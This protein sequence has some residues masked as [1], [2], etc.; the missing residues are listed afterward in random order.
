MN[1]FQKTVESV[2]AHVLKDA[3]YHLESL[4]LAVESVRVSPAMFSLFR[5]GPRDLFIPEQLPFL[6]MWKNLPGCP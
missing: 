2:T 4:D 3:F 5:K 1:T 6:K